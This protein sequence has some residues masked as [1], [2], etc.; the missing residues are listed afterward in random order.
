MNPVNCSCIENDPVA[1][2]W[3]SGNEL[4]EWQSIG[5][6]YPNFGLN[7]SG[8]VW[9]VSKWQSDTCL[10]CFC[11]YKFISD[12]FNRSLGS[13]EA[14]DRLKDP[15]MK[16]YYRDRVPWIQWTAVTLKNYPVALQRQSGNALA[17]WQSSGINWPEIDSIGFSLVKV[18][19]QWQSGSALDG[20]RFNGGSESG[21]N[22][23]FWLVESPKSCPLIGREDPR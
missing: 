19:F 20:F 5:T 15:E 12:R 6:I 9:V 4:A 14:S 23:G 18:A 22:R 2:Q 7:G 16:L 1:L 3:Q 21:W 8:L 10:V 11:F 13:I 17:K